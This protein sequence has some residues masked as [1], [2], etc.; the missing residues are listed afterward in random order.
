MRRHFRLEP[1]THSNH[2]E[3]GKGFGMKFNWP[4]LAMVAAGFLL[5]LF[6]AAT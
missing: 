6:G 3:T 2:G 1:A 5:L 4:G